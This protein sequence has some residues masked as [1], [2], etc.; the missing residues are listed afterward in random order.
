MTATPGPQVLS[1][2]IPV[3]N[4][5]GALGRLLDRLR[6]RRSR[7]IGRSKSSS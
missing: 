5:A 3:R 7:P 2:I 6:S 1:V 4:Q